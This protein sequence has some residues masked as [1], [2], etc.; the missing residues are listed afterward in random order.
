MNVDRYLERIAC[1]GSRDPTAEMLLK[2]HR[3]HLFAALL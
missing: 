1:T 3:T 2:L